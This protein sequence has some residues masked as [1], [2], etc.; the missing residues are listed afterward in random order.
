MDAATHEKSGRQTTLKWSTETGTGCT[1]SQ[2]ESRHGSRLDDNA[3]VTH[4]KALAPV[5]FLMELSTKNTQQ[6]Q[7]FIDA[8]SD[9]QV[10]ES[11]TH[12]TGSRQS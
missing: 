5:M 9:A 10:E 6:T 2:P 3:R 11:N 4:Q 7:A 1:V 8:N 12:H